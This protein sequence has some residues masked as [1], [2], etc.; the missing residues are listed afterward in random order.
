VRNFLTIWRRELASNF[1]S[2]VAYVLMVVFLAVAAGTFLLGVVR[3]GGSGTSLSVSLVESL[4]VWLT[5]LVTVVSMRLFAEEKRSGSLELLMTVPV[6]EAEIVLGKY[7][8]ALSFLLI[9]IAP[10]AVCPFLLVALSPGL[11]LHDLDAGAMLGGLV[12]MVLLSGFCVAVGLVVSLMTRN[13]MVAAISC[14]CAV[15][16]V[17]LA[18]W[19]LSMVPGV[20]GPVSDYLTATNHLVDFARGAVDT[21]PV[22]LYLS[23]TAFMLFAAV[24]LLESRRWR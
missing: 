21:R 13:Q 24:R 11:G 3:N 9:V 14:F 10:M 16:L 2:P 5:I 7:A 1:L 20:A 17:L 6:S 23:G 18:G 4:V 12:I 15:W 19:L 8:G 22:V